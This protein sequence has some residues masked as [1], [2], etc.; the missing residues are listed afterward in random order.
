MAFDFLYEK[1]KVFVSSDC[2]DKNYKK[3]RKKLKYRLEK[4]GFIKTYIFEQYGAASST[5]EEQF[6]EKLEDSHIVLFLTDNIDKEGKPPDG[7][8]KEHLTVNNINRN[9]IKIK[10]IY[11]F[12]NL[13]KNK[14][15]NIQKELES[16]GIDKSPK[17][18]EVTKFKEFITAGYESVIKE[19]FD[20]YI[21]YCRGRLSRKDEQDLSKESYSAINI[22][23]EQFNFSVV[24]K[25]YFKEFTKSQGSLWNTLFEIKKQPK[26]I[27]NYMDEFC[28][29]F[30]NHL[31]GKISFSELKIEKLKNEFRKQKRSNYIIKRWE[32]IQAY[33]TNDV[34]TAIDLL[35][36]SYADAESYNSPEWIKD[37]ILID[38]RDMEIINMT[39]KNQIRIP[40]AQSKLNKSTSFLTF[41]VIDRISRDIYS[42]LLDEIYEL[43]VQDPGSMRMSNILKSIIENIEK[44]TFVA[45]Y[46]G[47]LV[48][49]L[50]VRTILMEV[51]FH[52]AQHYSDSCLKYLCL[53]MSV[54]NKN[55][56]KIKKV[57]EHFIP[58]LNV[59]NFAK[60]YRL[61]SITNILPIKM[62]RDRVKLTIMQYMGYYLSDEDYL[63]C[64]KEVFKI[65]N[66]WIKDDKPIIALGYPIIK[67][68]QKNFMRMSVNEIL[69]FSI[70]ILQ[71][72]FR[73]FYDDI[74][75]LL[76]YIDFKNVEDDLIKQLIT[77]IDKFII[78][79]KSR[80]NLYK[81]QDLI[82]TL[83]K[84]CNKST[85]HWDHLIKKEWNNFYKN[86]YNLEILDLSIKT[87][88][89][90][91]LKFAKIISDRNK[92][93]GLKG[94]YS[95]YG[96]DLY[97]TI[98]NI[99]ND[100]NTK[101]D[102]SKILPTLISTILN[103]LHNA[104]QTTSE[105]SDCFKLLMSLQCR[106]LINKIDYNWKSFT[107]E[108]FKDEN[109]IYSSKSI[110]F[111]QNGSLYI[112]K[113]Y[114]FFY[115]VINNYSNELEVVPIFAQSSNLEKF[116]SYQFMNCFFNF[117]SYYE[118][119]NN[120]KIPYIQ[121]ILQI[122]LNKTYNDYFKTR[123]YTVSCL[124]ILCK[125]D[126]K[127]I[128]ISR[129]S[130]MMEDPD[131]RVRLRVLN[132]ITTIK[133]ID[134][135]FYNHIL[136]KAKVDNNYLIRSF[137]NS[138]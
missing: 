37:D 10:A 87:T 81:L 16:K 13:E 40:E 135:Q 116:E 57:F 115:K 129:L 121:N 113:L 29:Y 123:S 96:S 23:Q 60:I 27:S 41:P 30:M 124:G 100:K 131:Y 84:R 53:Q 98:I 52:F 114:S 11:I 138:I 101:I 107:V 43:T 86:I 36:Q 120:H 59:A 108:L 8:M 106:C 97:S 7:V 88:T 5:S 126:F 56:E 95:G 122:I 26:E 74:F 62:E 78:N 99:L 38:K 48:H 64:E 132:Q 34:D 50:L 49:L 77:I 136:Q 85:E 137:I 75:E 104:K 71:K 6:R 3:I 103:V 76:S 91:L 32:A 54:L 25:Q 130:E 44:Y 61:Y 12:C 69:K 67:C 112:L 33:H 66:K 47:S 42:D 24:N 68:M 105:K 125:S 4:A 80:N 46:Y 119:I 83:R 19:I 94:K 89:D 18:Q 17:F 128:A 28:F 127:D 2:R 82:I 118:Q 51:S 90:Y 39:M 9:S 117:L 22:N 73:R 55:T 1:I 65:T 20:T 72:E 102:L 58:Y 111:L 15:N 110:T 134:K 109:K 14:K 93:Q 92:T 45:V 133:K 21:S 35:S 70:N 31:L 79:K 63:K